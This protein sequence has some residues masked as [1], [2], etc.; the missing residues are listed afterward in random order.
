MIWSG[1]CAVDLRKAEE[2]VK[3]IM[4]SPRKDRVDW[5]IQH[6]LALYLRNIGDEQ[7]QKLLEDYCR[8][9]VPHNASQLGIDE[10]I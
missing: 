5:G 4:T 6:G 9:N 10:K 2:A 1:R 8:S 3:E 7:S